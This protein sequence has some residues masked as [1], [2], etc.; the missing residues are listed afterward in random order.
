MSILDTLTDNELA[1]LE[2]ELQTRIMH[3]HRSPVIEEREQLKASLNI[4]PNTQRANLIDVGF[5]YGVTSVF[6]AI[7]KLRQAR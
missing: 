6:S 4:E 5:N 7:R 3:D 1:Q 2:Q